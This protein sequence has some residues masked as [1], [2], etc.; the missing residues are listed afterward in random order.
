MVSV[1]FP[2]A[3]RGHRMGARRN[4]VFMK[5]AGGLMFLRT[6]RQFSKAKEIG[7]LVVVVGAGEVKLTQ[8]LLRHTPGLA[9]TKVV[10]GGSERQYSVANGL[11]AVSPQ[12]E[13]VLVHDAA[14]PLIAPSVI[15]AVTQAV[16]EHGAALAAVPSKDTIKVVDAAG[17]ICA[18]PDR[19]TLWAAQTPQG[20]RRELFVEAHAKAKAEGF[21]GTDDTILV[22]RLGHPVYVVKSDYRNLKI[23]TPDDLIIAEALLNAEALHKARRK[24]L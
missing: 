5:L 10:A 8:R 9:P 11:A 20:F 15:E 17:V 13:I 19:S 2:A 22:E 21:L 4:K 14:R 12:A 18:T 23:T 7:E 16:R 24:F 3:G 6:L 1:I